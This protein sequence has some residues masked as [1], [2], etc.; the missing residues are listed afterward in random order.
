MGITPLA[1]PVVRTC[2]STFLLPCLINSRTLCN[3]IVVAL[4]DNVGIGRKCKEA[5]DSLSCT[6]LATTDK[7]EKGK[8]TES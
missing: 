2:A 3:A 7:L 4:P 1:Q 6:A 5:L 8:R